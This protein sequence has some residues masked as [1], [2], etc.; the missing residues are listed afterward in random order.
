LQGSWSCPVFVFPNLGDHGFVSVSLDAKSLEYAKKNLAGMPDQFLRTML[1][2]GLWKMVRDTEMPLKNYIDIVD[3]HFAKESD[4]IATRQI[5]ST[6]GGSWGDT[7]TVLNYWPQ[8]DE[9]LRA[10]RLAFWEKM[11]TEYLRRFQGA[12]AGSD[13]QREWFDRYVALAR[14]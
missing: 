10:E 4:P 6:L 9:R 2:D 7:N 5:T 11:E 13:E 12:K 14:S 1:W 8:T 3:T